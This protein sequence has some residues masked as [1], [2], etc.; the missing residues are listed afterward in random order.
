VVGANLPV[1]VGRE[2]NAALHAWESRGTRGTRKK[3]GLPSSPVTRT[4]QATKGNAF[5]ALF[6]SSILI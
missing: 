4:I 5:V 1:Q 3:T 2:G 6:V